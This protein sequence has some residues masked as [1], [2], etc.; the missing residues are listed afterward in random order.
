MLLTL[1]RCSMN[2]CLYFFEWNRYVSTLID[3][4]N[5]LHSRIWRELYSLNIES[6]GKNHKKTKYDT[7][8][9][10]TCATPC[11]QLS[12]AC[13]AISSVSCSHICCENYFDP[14]GLSYERWTKPYIYG[15]AINASPNQVASTYNGDWSS[16]SWDPSLVK[17]FLQDSDSL[18]LPTATGNRTE[19]IYRKWLGLGKQPDFFLIGNW[20]YRYT[21]SD[22]A[23]WRTGYRWSLKN[24]RLR[25]SGRV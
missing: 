7:H 24:G 6:A 2:D 21:S 11:G 12:V 5:S 4:S 25:L 20:M 10:S 9:M 22:M 23:T 16:R 1:Q 13:N 17:T 18:C 14:W 3:N 19:R 8:V 15:S